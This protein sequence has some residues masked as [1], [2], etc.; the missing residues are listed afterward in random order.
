M[1]DRGADLN[2]VTIREGCTLIHC[3]VWSGKN[4]D[5]VR[6]TQR[7][8]DI[9]DK[10]GIDT[11]VYDADGVGGGVHA[12]ARV[13]NE[14]R[15][16]PDPETRRP[17]GHAIRLDAYHGGGVFLHPDRKVPGTTT[18]VKDYFLNPKAEN[19]WSLRRRFEESFKARNGLPFDRENY[20]S[21]SPNI[22]DIGK[23]Q[24]ELGQPTYERNTAQKIAVDKVPDGH[25]SPNRSDATVICFSKRRTPLNFSAALLAKI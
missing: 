22:P 8:F 2:C 16:R 17:I 24:A 12:A 3:E 15:T 4:S 21:I 1:A 11:L 20:I 10:F 19:H 23:L 25:A 9:V 18:K 14:A 7:A 5:L 6:T 13:I